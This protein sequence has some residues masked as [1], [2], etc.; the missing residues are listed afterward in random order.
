MG[1][2]AQNVIKL[3]AL[4]FLIKYSR[5]VTKWNTNFSQLAMLPEQIGNV[6]PAELLKSLRS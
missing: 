4:S 5:L 1:L 3:R 2:P 6:I